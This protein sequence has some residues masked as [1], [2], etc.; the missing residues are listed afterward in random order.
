MCV[1]FGLMGGHAIFNAGSAKARKEAAPN[2]ESSIDETKTEQNRS[3]SDRC[4]NEIP[5][6][7][8]PCCLNAL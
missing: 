2:Q 4:G 6:G 3:G 5:E 7:F 8:T 1:I